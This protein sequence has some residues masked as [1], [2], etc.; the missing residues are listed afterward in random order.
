MLA[1]MDKKTDLKVVSVRLSAV[2]RRRL[3]REKRATGK[4]IQALVA[5]SLDT[6]LPKYS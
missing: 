5:E 1:S 4:S 2:L 6:T 3:I